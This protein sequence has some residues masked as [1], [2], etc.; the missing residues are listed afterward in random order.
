MKAEP[1]TAR[2]TCLCA[3]ML[4]PHAVQARVKDV[5]VQSELRAWLHVRG[6]DPE[7]PRL[8]E[9]VDK[10]LGQLF[11]DE[12]VDDGGGSGNGEGPAMSVGCSGGGAAI[13]SGG[14]GGWGSRPSAEPSLTTKIGRNSYGGN[15]SNG[16]NNSYGGGYSGETKLPLAPVANGLL[17][18]C[19][20]GAGGTAVGGRHSGGGGS[21]AVGGRYSGGG[22]STTAA[23][24]Y[25]GGGGVGG[26]DRALLTQLLTAQAAGKVPTAPAPVGSAAVLMQMRRTMIL[27]DVM[28]VSGGELWMCVLGCGCVLRN[29]ARP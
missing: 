12:D 24:R 15:N 3:L 6:R 4:P 23:G 16:G 8:P 20:S 27:S 18:Q 28:A 10:L 1:Q 2:L 21:T 9:T 14:G 5:L 22:G 29:L 17:G 26:G 13:S 7:P 19:S 25:S 11:G